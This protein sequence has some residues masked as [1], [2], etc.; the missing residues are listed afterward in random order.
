MP[1]RWFNCCS[2][3][4]SGRF[5]LARFI[6]DLPDAPNDAVADLR[7]HFPETIGRAPGKWWALSVAQLSA[8]DRY[9]TLSAADTAAR[10]DRVL[11]FSIP[12]LD[13]PS[14]D[15]SLGDYKTFR[16]LPA[17]RAVL[18]KVSQQLLLLGARA[19]PSYRAIVQEDH[20]L[21]ELLAR[22][23]THRVPERLE[24]VANYRAVIERQG[25]AIDDYLNWYEATQSNTTS[26]AFSQIL[27]AAEATGEALPRRRDRISVYLDSVEL[28]MN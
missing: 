12:A 2:T 22:D 28:E 14:R 26:G 7:A 6:T 11:R 13:G 5:K 4:P 21:A 19:H 17:S 15:Y 27:E 16:E 1:G 24:R 10:L 8:M 23:R 9:E 25:R 3:S 18:Q 20:E